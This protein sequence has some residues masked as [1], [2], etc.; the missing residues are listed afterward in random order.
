MKR[1]K[2]AFF[3]GLLLSNVASANEL[4]L[5]IIAAPKPLNWNSVNGLLVSTALNS[6]HSYAIGHF[7]V[8]VKCDEPN[9]F[10]VSHFLT[11]MSPL[12]GRR[13]NKLILKSGLGLQT[14]FYPFEGKLD[15][16]PGLISDFAEMAAKGRYV[17]FVVPTTAQACRNMMNFAEAWIKFGG[18]TVY[19]G[20]KDTARGEGAGCA[21]FAERFYQLATGADFPENWVVRKEV[22]VRM[23][24]GDGKRVSLLK[25][26]LRKRWKKGNEEFVTYRSPEPTWA[27]FDS[28][29]EGFDPQE[30]I[31]PQNRR[32]NWETE[33]I[34][35][36]SFI[37]HETK[38]EP[39]EIWNKIRMN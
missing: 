31:N 36:N 18:Y 19:G 26:L 23:I 33:V 1:L 32:P 3:L 21:D 12:D 17:R 16:A 22:P 37:R 35:E 14:L 30:L 9:S 29:R 34:D 25:L 4:T 28:V 7:A 38:I 27:F 5:H 10:G 11:S 8:E 2:F 39:Q 13:D 24:G 15:D 20:G 6:L